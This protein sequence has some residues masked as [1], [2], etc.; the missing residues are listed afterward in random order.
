MSFRNPA[1]LN[2]TS[3]RANGA[4]LCLCFSLFLS[5]FESLTITSMLAGS[6]TSGGLALEYCLIKQVE[7]LLLR[8][9]VTS[10]GRGRNMC[11]SPCFGCTKTNVR[12]RDCAASISAF[13]ATTHLV[14]VRRRLLPARRLLAPQTQ[15][16]WRARERSAPTVF[17]KMRVRRC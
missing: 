10:P 6:R 4:S 9:S 17:S 11:W 1:F 12:A 8:V 16:N 7:S 15:R 5:H 13:C 2:I 14:C 3:E